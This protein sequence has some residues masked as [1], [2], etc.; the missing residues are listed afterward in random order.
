MGFVHAFR[1]IFELIKSER[2]F[3]VHVVAL[4]LVIGLGLY[5]DI[6]QGEWMLISIVSS[7]VLMAEALNSAIEKLADEV[8]KERKPSIKKVKDM[9]A[10]GVLISAIS[11]AIVGIWIFWKYLF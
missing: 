10:G 3:Q 2:N 4:A 7:I 8:T 9:A 11:A 6:K 5:C 1:G